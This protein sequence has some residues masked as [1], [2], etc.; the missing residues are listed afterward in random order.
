MLHL[1]TETR[2]SVAQ[3]P[4]APVNTTVDRIRQHKALG[5]HLFS[6]DSN[7]EAETLRIRRERERILRSFKSDP[8]RTPSAAAKIIQ[9]ILTQCYGFELTRAE[10]DC[11]RA[12]AKSLAEMPSVEVE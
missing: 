3:I 10:R 6:L 1:S 2:F 4:P 9:Y 12:V 11:L 8:P 5:R 7:D